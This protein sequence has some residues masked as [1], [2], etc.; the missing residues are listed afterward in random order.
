[1]TTAPNYQQLIS[2]ELERIDALQSAI[3]EGQAQLVWEAGDKE[4][5]ASIAKQLN[6]K[7]AEV[8]RRQATLGELQKRASA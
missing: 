1:M 6:F 2:V 8:K 5:C 4:M 7:L 3:V